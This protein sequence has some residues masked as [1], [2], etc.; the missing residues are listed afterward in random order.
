MNKGRIILLN[1]VSSSGKSTLSR[2]LV[3]QLDGFF[4]LSIDDYDG[5]IEK[6][7]DRETDHLIPV[8]TEYFYHRTLAMFSDLGVNVIAD[9]ILHDISTTEDCFNVLQNYPV[10]FVGV[11]CSPAALKRREEQRGD[12]PIG[13]AEEQLAYVHRHKHLYH[14]EI[15]T[16]ND[17]IADCA[18]QIRHAF[19]KQDLISGWPNAGA[20]DKS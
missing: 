9:Q 15:D 3:G 7:E 19:E 4:H 16:S 5:F 12:R 18:E 8:P 13:Q 11:H 1:G 6:A 10:F 2:E 20:A 14:L 17:S